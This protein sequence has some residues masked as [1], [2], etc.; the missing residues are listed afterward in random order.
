MKSIIAIAGAALA[1]VTLTACGSD[2][3]ETSEAT[4]SERDYTYAVAREVYGKDPAE[5]TR[6]A[7][8]PGSVQRNVAGAG[9]RCRMIDDLV[10]T[11]ELDD[12]AGPTSNAEVLDPIVRAEAKEYGRTE[13]QVRHWYA[14][15]ATYGCKEHV[16]M[17]GSYAR[18]SEA[19]GN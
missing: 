6:V 7:D 13:G 4:M 9:E 2:N 16:E 1:A 15:G 10:R 18:Y 11:G 14:L 3:S 5:S 12:D 19:L 8:D 17:L